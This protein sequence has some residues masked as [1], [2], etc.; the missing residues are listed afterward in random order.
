MSTVGYLN[1]SHME[2]ANWLTTLNLNHLIPNFER[3]QIDGSQLATLSDQDLRLKLRISKPAEVIAIKGA[4]SKLLDD[5]LLLNQEGAGPN[6]VTW[7]RA[8]SYEKDNRHGNSNTLPMLHR[9]TVSITSGLSGLTG[10]SSRQP[11]MLVQ[12]CASELIDQSRYSGWI[13]KQGGSYKSCEF[14]CVCEGGGVTW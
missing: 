2:V 1:W 5:E 7:Q 3:M 14:V 11:P 13:R 8:G 10:T 4:I 6:L 12:G 9:N